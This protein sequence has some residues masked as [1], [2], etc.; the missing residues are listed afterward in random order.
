MSGNVTIE[1]SNFDKFRKG[2]GISFGSVGEDRGSSLN[3]VKF[4]FSLPFVGCCMSGLSEKFNGTGVEKPLL[5]RGYL[6]GSII[7]YPVVF[8]GDVVFTVADIGYRILGK[9]KE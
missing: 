9:G 3:L 1:T 6:C 8:V 2:Y 5:V 7:G 4:L